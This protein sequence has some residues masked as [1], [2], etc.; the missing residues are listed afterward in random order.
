MTRITGATAAFA[1]L[2]VQAGNASDLYAYPKQGQSAAQQS[3]DDD[4]C[5]R[6][7]QGQ[8]GYDPRRPT[9]SY[10]DT[11]GATGGGMLRGAL[12]GA[13][14]GEIADDKA[15]EGAAIGALLGGVRGH[16]SGRQQQAAAA[17]SER[18]SFNRAYKACMDA[19]GYSVN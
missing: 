11:S 17:A 9:S 5:Y 7:A 8:T 13:A 2:L 19:R 4:Q 15:G 12:L 1:F 3:E 10:G 16:N 18:N 14:V 6:W